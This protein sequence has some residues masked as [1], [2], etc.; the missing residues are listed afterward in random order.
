MQAAILARIQILASIIYCLMIADAAETAGVD[1]G[2]ASQDN[3][4]TRI[5]IPRKSREVFERLFSSWMICTFTA[6]RRVEHPDL[7]GAMSAVGLLPP[8]RK[9]ILGQHLD[10]LY[11]CTRERIVS[12]IQGTKFVGVTMDGWKK[13]AAEQGAPLVTVNILMP[14]SGAAFWK[15]C[16]QNILIYQP[17]ILCSDLTHLPAGMNSAHE[18]H[19]S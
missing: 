16:M 15:V 11:H 14:G 1:V 10:S 12:D 4:L 3:A 5:V 8:A 7:L 9:A 18:R 6:A 2:G 13:R 17:Y 19:R